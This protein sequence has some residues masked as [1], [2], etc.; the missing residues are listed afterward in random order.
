MSEKSNLDIRPPTPDDWKFLHELGFSIFPLHP[1]GKTPLV[2]WKPYQLVKPDWP[3]IEQWLERYP[4]ANIGIVTGAI[5]GIVAVDFDS[6]EAFETAQRK[7]LLGN[8]LINQTGRGYHAI[9][10]YPD[11][12]I[13]TTTGILPNVD[14]RGDGGYIVSPPSI[15][16]DGHVYRW[17]DGD[18]DLT[19]VQMPAKMHDLL[20][21]KS[22]H[23]S[24]PS[25]SLIIPAPLQRQ[26]DLVA[27]APQGSRND[28]L[29]KSAYSVAQMIGGGLMDQHLATGELTIS[30]LQ[31]GLPP[32]EILATITSALNAG[33]L[34]PLSQNAELSE[35]RIAQVFS[36][37]HGHDRKFCHTSGSWFHFNGTDW[38]KSDKGSEREIIRQLARKESGGRAS[39]AKNSVVSG[40]ESLAK[41]DH[42]HAVTSD[43][44]DQNPYLLGTPAGTVDLKTGKLRPANAHDGITKVTAC[45]PEQGVPELWGKFLLEASGGDPELV[46]Y[47]QRMCGYILTGD[48]CEHA[49][50][51]VHGFGGNGKSVFLNTIAGIM[52]DHATTASM[53]TFVANQFLSHTAD[54]AMLKGARLVSASETEAGK[55]W[56][57]SRIKQ[58]TGGDKITARFMHKNFFTYQ[59][60][61]KLLI[62]GNHAPELGFV[63]DA[64]RRRFNILPFVHKPKN[65]DKHLESK[66]KD[67]WPKILNW[68]IEGCL[69]WQREGLNPPPAVLAATKEFFDDQDAFSQWLRANCTVDLQSSNLK[70]PCR[71]L[72]QSWCDFA[73]ESSEFSGSPKSFGSR[74]KRMGI[75]SKTAT[76]ATTKTKVKHYIGIGLNFLI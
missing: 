65:P 13:Q 52:K 23:V 55:A 24:Q 43:F 35:D 41:N 29:N 7:G 47:L 30:A 75:T 4:D 5:S 44:W 73:R 14:V 38:E 76:C 63:D 36:E 28:Q 66:L 33:L 64:I 46:A 27:N 50:F 32:A 34:V 54:L 37:S 61:F 67:E 70:T 22:Q 58:M 3:Q 16:P 20:T 26:C 51:F 17:L 48:T 2:P 49:L 72:Y 1:N 10:P 69:V 57:E 74:L 71:G 45:G 62:V 18:L 6:Q 60:L 25:P 42:A 53:D 9:F 12:P 19:K 21:G 59:P 68:M 40:V 31:A 56:A 15:H 11:T 8:A 39:F